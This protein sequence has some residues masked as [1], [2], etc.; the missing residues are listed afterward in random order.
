M[1]RYPQIGHLDSYEP[2]VKPTG[3]KVGFCFYDV[4]VCTK[5]QDDSLE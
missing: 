1:K 5:V 2:M 3:E 4:F